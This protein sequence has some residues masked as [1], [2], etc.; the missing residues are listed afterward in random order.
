MVLFKNNNFGCFIDSLYLVKYFYHILFNSLGMVFFMFLNIFIMAD[1]KSLSSKSSIKSTS[2]IVLITPYSPL[3][4]H[5]LMFLFVS[6]NFLLL[7]LKTKHFRSHNV[8]TLK[9]SPIQNFCCCS[10][11][12]FF[13]FW[14]FV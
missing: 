3:Y 13:F 2:G 9:I 7:L 14:L 11:Q 4:N 6:Q 5:T 12:V 10:L 8:P 1:L